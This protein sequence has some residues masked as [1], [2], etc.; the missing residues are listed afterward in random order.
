MI[1]HEVSPRP[2]GFAFQIYLLFGKLIE[3]FF[4]NKQP[5]PAPDLTP[6][7]PENLTAEQCVVLWQEVYDAGEELLLAGLARDVG[8]GGD[9]HRA[10]RRWNEER[11]AEHDEMIFH[12]LANLHSREER[13]AG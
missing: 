10:Y 12:M 11:L 3:E 8:P 9:V 7:L 1:C 6:Y 5:T 2:I 13:R 4:M